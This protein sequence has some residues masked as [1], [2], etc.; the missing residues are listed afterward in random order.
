[1]HLAAARAV[2]QLHEIRKH[3]R[4][5]KQDCVPEPV[6]SLSRRSSSMAAS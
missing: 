5:V 3:D 2:W 1:M 6:P 4:M